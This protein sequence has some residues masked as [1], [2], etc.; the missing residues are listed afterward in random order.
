M[1]YVSAIDSTEPLRYTLPLGVRRPLFSGASGKAVLAF[2]SPEERERYLSGVEFFQ[3]TPWSP[4]R[5]EMPALLRQIRRDAVV[6]DRNGSFEGATA[7]SS[8]VF[9]MHGN[10]F[11]AVSLAGPTERM[12]ANRERFIALNKSASERISRSLGYVGVYPPA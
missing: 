10:A 6:Y 4:S 3:M 11:A 1:V 8:P 7:I 5:E 9:D 2:F 12:D